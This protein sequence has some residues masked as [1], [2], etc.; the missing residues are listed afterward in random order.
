[1]QGTVN[2]IVQVLK[3]EAC[4]EE[5]GKRKKREGKI[6]NFKEEGEEKKRGLWGEKRFRLQGLW[7]SVTDRWV[8]TIL[9]L[10]LIL[11]LQGGLL[12]WVIKKVI[13]FYK[14]IYLCVCIH[15]CNV[16]KIIREKVHFGNNQKPYTGFSSLQICVVRNLLLKALN[17]QRPMRMFCLGPPLYSLWFQR[18][19]HTVKH[20]CKLLQDSGL[21]YCILWPIILWIYFQYEFLLNSYIQSISFYI[22]SV[23]LFLHPAWN[24]DYFIKKKNCFLIWIWIF[25]IFG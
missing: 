4:F 16:L 20:I 10:R 22:F 13:A 19:I 23:F 24:N 1:M 9:V 12:P 25:K 21:Q 17:L 18:V 5:T 7:M 3:K 6:H 14:C 15:I 8:T 2:W 11:Y